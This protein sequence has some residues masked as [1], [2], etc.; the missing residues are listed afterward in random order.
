MLRTVSWSVASVRPPS[1]DSTETVSENTPEV[2]ATTGTRT[3]VFCVVRVTVHT[4]EVADSVHDP[5]GRRTDRNPS[6]W[7][8]TRICTR[9]GYEALLKTVIGI[10]P[11]RAV[12]VIDWLPGNRTSDVRPEIS[13][14]APASS[15]GR[16]RS[17][18]SA[19]SLTR[20]RRLTSEITGAPGGTTAASDATGWRAARMA[21]P[22]EMG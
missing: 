19:D 17:G 1:G 16:D 2:R 20:I 18:R 3:V 8:D 22:S 10:N 14:V 7:L 9:R 11:W 6:F 15:A 12:K 21:A 4:S 13:L 5:P